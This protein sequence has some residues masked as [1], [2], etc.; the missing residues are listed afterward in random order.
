MSREGEGPIVFEIGV[1]EGNLTFDVSVLF[2]TSNGTAD[3]KLLSF[4]C[5][6]FYLLAI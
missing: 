1:L 3:G 2:F 6:N 5:V 4:V